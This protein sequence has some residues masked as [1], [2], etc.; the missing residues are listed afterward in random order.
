MAVRGRDRAL[1]ALVI[2][3]LLGAACSGGSDDDAAGDGGEGAGRAAEQMGADAQGVEVEENL[4][5]LSDESGEGAAFT[6]VGAASRDSD[7]P[8]PAPE[9]RDALT[10]GPRVIKT[11]DLSLEVPRKGF[12]ASV[13]DSI[14][15]AQDNGGFV[16]AT[17]VSGDR[18]MRG[19]VVLRI[20]AENFELALGALKGLGEL[21][22]ETVSGQDVTEEF[23]DLE[24]R[25]R[26]LEAQEV[27]LLRLMDRAQTV[28]ATI[29]VQR[30]LSGV[31]LEVERL[32]GRLRFLEDQTAFGTIRMDL[33]QA[34]VSPAQK[35]G[36][37]ERAWETAKDTTIAVVSGVIVGA[38][39]VLPV[40]LLLAL[41]AGAVRLARPRFT[42]SS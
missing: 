19:T 36:A 9:Q 20:P 26:N 38:G 37:I 4:K 40:A 29:K 15:V 2:V 33:L 23:V 5:G 39:F 11:A 6:A 17:E 14:D 7:Q 8:Q 41:A 28:V 42:G 25:L 34:G 3:A 30:E 16:L 24:A 31:Q 35:P 18:K 13:Q 12:R 32:R 21:K 1:L 10:V 22:S 27:V